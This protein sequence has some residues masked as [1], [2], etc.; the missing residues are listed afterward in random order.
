L[1]RLTAAGIDAFC[2]G[3]ASDW[4]QHLQS[5]LDAIEA[6]R[7]DALLLSYERLHAEPVAALLDVCRFLGWA[8]DPDVCQRAV[9]HHQFRNCRAE[10]KARFGAE[11]AFYRRGETHGFRDELDERTIALLDRTAAPVYDRAQ[12]LAAVQRSKRPA[13]KAA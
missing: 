6:G 8:E 12:Q 11:N 2:R 13:I 1:G 7:L 3:L 10:A 9:D 5:Y 4:V